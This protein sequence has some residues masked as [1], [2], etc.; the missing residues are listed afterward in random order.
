[1]QLGFYFDQRRCTACYTCVVA[2]KQWNDVPA[3]SASWRWVSTE[4]KGR[5]PDL[6]VSHLSLSCCHCYNPACIQACP[7]SAISKRDQDGIVLVDRDACSSGCRA[8]RDAC[9]F[10][11]PQFREE[12]SKMEMCDFC[13]DR[14]EEGKQPLCVTSCPLRALD[15]GSMEELK[16]TYGTGALAPGFP[17]PSDTQPAI[18]F[19]A[20]ERP[21]AADS[22]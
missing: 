10:H 4:E 12:T 22:R 21:C 15:S 2:C 8:C 11:A 5:F 1:M 14:L 17:D 13:L 20:K 3:G 6:W 7:T 19:R 9:P 16:A 18:I